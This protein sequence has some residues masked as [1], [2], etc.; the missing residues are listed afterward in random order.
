[1]KLGDQYSVDANYV[2]D[3]SSDLNASSEELS[4][5]LQTTVQAINEISK[6]AEE[7]SHGSVHF[8]ERT[9]ELLIEL[10]SKFTV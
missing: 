3:I 9:S 7:S 8:A 4:S 2:S 5:L 10:V 6:T 1:M